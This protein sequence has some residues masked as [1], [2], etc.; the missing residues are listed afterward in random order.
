MAISITELLG[1]ESVSGTRAVINDNFNILADEINLIEGYFNVNT[2]Q[3]TSLSNLTTDNFTVGLASAKL[4]I[5]PS[6]FVINTMDLNITA[7][8]VLSGNIFVDSVETN[9]INDSNNTSPYDLGSPT[10]IPNKTVYR[11]SNSLTSAFTILLYNGDSGQDIFFVYDA[12]TTGTVTVKA[13]SGVSILLGS[14][15]TD[16]NL[17]KI[18]D[19]VHLKCVKNGSSKEWYIVGG[20]GYT[21]A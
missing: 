9:S 21:L 16:I 12:N 19:T 18:G 8:L 2:G 6:S 3:I 10:N 20:N 5:T 15:L 13:A 11:V 4:S 7:D 14:S 17:S 1:S